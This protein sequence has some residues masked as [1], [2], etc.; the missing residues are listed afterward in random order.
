MQS[1]NKNG[2]FDFSD[3]A[4]VFLTFGLFLTNFFFKVVKLL[5][6]AIRIIKL[7]KVYQSRCYSNRKQVFWGK[8]SIFWWLFVEKIRDF[9]LDL[10]E[11]QDIR[12]GV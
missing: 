3:F 8:I 4:T 7:V 5:L 11:E 12:G 9:L 2:F 10:T 6:L 1:E